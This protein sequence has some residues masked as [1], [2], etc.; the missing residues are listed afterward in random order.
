MKATNVIGSTATVR[1]KCI[2][3]IMPYTF[4]PTI[5]LQVAMC[6]EEFL[7]QPVRQFDKSINHTFSLQSINKSI[8]HRVKHHLEHAPII[9]IFEFFVC[10]F[11]FF[12][13][14]CSFWLV[15][16]FRFLLFCSVVLFV[17]FIYL[18]NLLQR[19]CFLFIYLFL[20]VVLPSNPRNITVPFVNQSSALMCWLPP[21][22]TGGQ[23]FYE[24]ECKRTCELNGKDCA[25][26]T[27]D[28]D[29][30]F[31]FK[32]KIYSTKVMIPEWT[33]ALS[34]YV[35]YTCNIIARNRVSEMAKR[36]HK[37]EASSATI[38]FRT[39]GSGKS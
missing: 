35:N 1:E 32:D 37:I 18:L 26:E 4:F 23:V 36:K 5:F 34:A 39:K 14:L 17:C 8:R 29:A 12:F 11:V 16:L 2:D 6:Y 7:I 28:D 30:G 31:V 22:I 10:V 19:H 9:V 13:L 27:C 3:R 24:L 33:R 38:S 20:C 25:E 21:V 15:G